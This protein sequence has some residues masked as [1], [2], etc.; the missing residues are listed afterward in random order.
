MTKHDQIAKSWVK[1]NASQLQ[2]I[3]YFSGLQIKSVRTGNG[4]NSARKYSVVDHLRTRHYWDV[5]A[6]SYSK[7]NDPYGHNPDGR[8]LNDAE[9][10]LNPKFL[11]LINGI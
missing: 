5:I 9:I 6:Y 8:V 1:I 10:Y 11:H 4:Y 3:L 7:V 2:H